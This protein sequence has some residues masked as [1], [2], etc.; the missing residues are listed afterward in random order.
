MSSDP[1]S[2]DLDL[3]QCRVRQRRVLDVMQA[4]KLDAVLVTQNQHVHYLTGCRFAWTFQPAALLTA[5]G[6]MTLVAPQKEPEASA[7]D[8]ILVYEAKKLSTLRNDQRH[9]SAEVLL[10]KLAGKQTYTRIGVEFSSIGRYYDPIIGQAIDVEPDLY[11]LRLRKDPDEIALIRKAIAAT[12]KMYEV[13]RAMIHP[14]VS[15][16]EVFNALQS[17]AVLECGEMLT[18]TGND[19]QCCARGGA[20]RTRTT[21]AG[22][23][24][25]LDLGPAYRGYF[26]DN[27]R[28]IAVTEVDDVQRAAWEK[29]VSVF[30]FVEA[31]ARPGQSCREL[32]EGA[33]KILSEAAVGVFN[34]HLGH[35]I[36]LFPHEGPHLNPNWDDTLEPG[37]IL[38]V[39]PGLYDPRLR[40]GI[41]IENNYLVT[42][43]GVE[44]LSNF[45]MEL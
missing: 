5:D 20:P 11:R 31:V 36:G 34:H 3:N 39:E 30:P 19:Y 9:A 16:L 6:R 45:P 43:T 10:A 32:F 28:T 18:G 29:I 42:E 27:C 17:A 44:R 35:G 41:R 38:A 8:E 2:I 24:Y 40:A 33:K 15:E 22:E 7:A 1:S 37:N 12:G 23:L 13:A 25:I 21:N 26:A 4:Q 14:G